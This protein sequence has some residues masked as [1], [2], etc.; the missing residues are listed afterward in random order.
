MGRLWG[1][2]FDEKHLRMMIQTMTPRT[3]FFKVI[4]EEL[5]KLGRWKNLPRGA[6]RSKR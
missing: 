3:R 5:R 6:N 1:R 2:Q 4:R